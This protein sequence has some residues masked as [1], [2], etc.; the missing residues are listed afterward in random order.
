METPVTAGLRN[1]ASSLACVKGSYLCDWLAVDVADRD[2][3]MNRA[4]LLCGSGYWQK[5]ES[6]VGWGRGR[7]LA[8]SV[9]VLG[10]GEERLCFVLFGICI[11]LRHF[12]L[13]S[14][15]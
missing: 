5:S 13:V 14:F 12:A 1:Y 7:C 2:R 8:G 9:E 6:P 4:D 10:S 15:T 11:Q 3:F